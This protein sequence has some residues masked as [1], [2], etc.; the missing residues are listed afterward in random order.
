MVTVTLSEGVEAIAK[1]R[2]MQSYMI[3]LLPKPLASSSK[4]AEGRDGAHA[5][6]PARAGSH[7]DNAELLQTLPSANLGSGEILEALRQS[8]A[9]H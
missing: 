8:R 3:I 7:A 2:S 4:Q 6:Q 1:I 5:H 9:E